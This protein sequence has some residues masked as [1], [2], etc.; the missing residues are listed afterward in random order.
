MKNSIVSRK[1]LEN[2][3]ILTNLIVI[4]SCI[5]QIYLFLLSQFGV[6][7]WIKIDVNIV[8]HQKKNFIWKWKIK[9]DHFNLKIYS[10]IHGKLIKFCVAMFY[11]HPHF[12]NL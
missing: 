2:Q 1:R 5:K 12:I 8:T 7:S 4:F 10:K 6:Q 11:G 3:I 9:T